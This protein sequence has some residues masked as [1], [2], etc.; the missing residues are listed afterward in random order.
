MAKTGPARQSSEPEKNASRHPGENFEVLEA[1]LDSLNV[2]IANVLPSGLVLY[3]NPRFCDI[4]GITSTQPIL[5]T[6]LR[7][8]VAA[9]SWPPSKKR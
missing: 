7:Y 4:L 6:E 3:C 5:G 8:H 2:G 1:L 9:S